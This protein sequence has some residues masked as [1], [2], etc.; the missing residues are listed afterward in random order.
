MNTLAI[1]PLSLVNV[2]IL[3]MSAFSLAWIGR[4]VCAQIHGYIAVFI[5]V[6]AIL[7][8]MYLAFHAY[9]HWTDA[10]PT[11]PWE[12]I[13]NVIGLLCF[14]AIIIVYYRSTRRL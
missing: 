4:Q 7:L 9:Q 8:A 11:A 6:W 3:A 5:R 1:P 12:L 13:R 2:I 10:L 14:V